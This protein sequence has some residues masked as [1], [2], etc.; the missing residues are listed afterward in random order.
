MSMRTDMPKET[1]PLP[2]AGTASQSMA[3]AQ[4]KAQVRRQM[5][6]RL[7]RIPPATWQAAGQRIAVALETMA[8][9]RNA[10]RIALYLEIAAEVPASFLVTGCRKRECKLYLPVYDAECKQ[11][12][13]AEWR[14]GDRLHPGVYGIREPVAPRWAP[15]THLDLILVPGRAFT[16]TGM[17]LGRGGGYFDRFLTAPWAAA[18]VFIG[19]ALE[20][21]LVDDL[22][23]DT[24]DIGMDWVVTEKEIHVGSR[25]CGGSSDADQGPA[26]GG[27][28]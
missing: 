20:C 27:R 7:H 11:Y 16:G 9:W 15:E 18:A 4:T 17:R 1:K 10:R 8:V 13:P 12:V 25:K 21:Q 24:H 3:V 22:P 5:A 23:A 26:E 14:A 28:E 19:L 6:Q 2:A